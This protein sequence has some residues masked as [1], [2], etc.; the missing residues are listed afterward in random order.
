[1]PRH[2]LGVVPL[3][4]RGRES[5]DKVQHAGCPGGRLLPGLGAGQLASLGALHREL[6]QLVGPGVAGSHGELEAF[7]PLHGALRD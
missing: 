7:E 5:A 4:D 2:G 3:L 6:G 1:M